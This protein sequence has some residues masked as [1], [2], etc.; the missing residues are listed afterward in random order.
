ME[1]KDLSLSTSMQ[2]LQSQLQC[3]TDADSLQKV[4]DLFNLNIRKKDIIRAGQ[5]SELQDA[6]SQQMAERVNKHAGEFSNKDLLD[7]FKV[8][9]E[10]VSKSDNLITPE[11]MPAIQVNQQNVHI[12]VGDTELSRDSKEKVMS[13]VQE[14]LAKLN[15]T[16]IIDVEPTEIKDSEENLNDTGTSE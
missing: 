5:L 15:T 3:A 12:N 6:I 9:G 2:E 4:V 14:I 10:T 13:K 16:N 11:N 1:E 7:Y 8:I